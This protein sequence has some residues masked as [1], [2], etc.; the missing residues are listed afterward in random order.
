MPTNWTTLEE[1][2][3]YLETHK[4]PRLNHKETDNL[5][6]SITSTEIEFV[7]LKVP[8]KQNFRNR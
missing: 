7:I 1:K 3:K 6:H 2:D 8:S 5:N 4:L